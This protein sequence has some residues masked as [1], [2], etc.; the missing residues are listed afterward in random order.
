MPRM[1]TPLSILVAL[2]WCTTLQAQRKPPAAPVDISQEPHH[3]I[4]FENPTVRVFR[5]E[6]QSNEETLPHRHTHFYA[7]LS[8][9]PVTIANEV[10]GRPPVVVRLESA[11]VHT[12][13]GGFRVAER[14]KSPEPARIIII[15]ALKTESDG[16]AAPVALRYHDAAFAD[17]LQ[18]PGMRG[19]SM[20][21]AAGGQIENREE[22]YDRLIL[23]IS[24]LKLRE[25]ATGQPSSELLMKAGDIKWVPHGAS[26]A[27]TNTGSAPAT[28]ITFEIPN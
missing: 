12:S 20:I 8:L 21:L 25:D 19:Y 7:F 10:R 22:R 11:E 13:K 6:L 14:N 23:A 27:T 3:E 15:E 28:F 2:L 1:K 16:F 4:L 26:H 17:L 24:D 5:L 9:Q 18:S